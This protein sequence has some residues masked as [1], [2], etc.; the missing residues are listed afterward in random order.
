MRLGVLIAAL[1]VLGA[2]GYVDRNHT[3][4]VSRRAS[5]DSWWC[6][7]EQIR[8]TGFDREAHYARWE[9]REKGYALGGGVLGVAI[10]VAGG[11]RLRLLL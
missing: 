10:L 5:S 11:R 2:A 7:H 3:R 1:A 8:C 6:A 4:A 9:L